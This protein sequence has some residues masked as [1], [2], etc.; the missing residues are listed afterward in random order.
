M[1]V[2][3]SVNEAELDAWLRQYS[4]G[5]L[6]SLEPIKA[7]IENTNYFV[8]TAQGAY[9]LTLFERLPAA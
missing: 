7:G 6:K 4:V 2:Y 8:T 3:T 1:S 9:V 5:E